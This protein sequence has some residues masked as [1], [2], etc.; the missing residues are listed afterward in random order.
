[1]LGADWSLG[2]TTVAGLM[3][4]HSQVD[5]SYR[6]PRGNGEIESDITGLYP[7][8]RLALNER[9]S[10]WAV[11]GYGEGMLTL[12]P[13]GQEATTPD[14]DMMMAAAGPAGHHRRRRCR[15]ADAGGEDRR[16]GGEHVLG[17][18]A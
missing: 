6:S 4:S 3:L 5:G 8:G 12:K 16:D 15:K 14:M 2:R 17:W 18:D 10:V 13:E 7:Y 1:M 9:V 11:M